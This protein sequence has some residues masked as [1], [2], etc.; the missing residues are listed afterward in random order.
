MYDL[1]HPEQAAASGAAALSSRIAEYPTDALRRIGGYSGAFN[2]SN[3][4]L[5]YQRQSA[6]S[7]SS[8]KTGVEDLNRKITGDTGEMRAP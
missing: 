2:S 7:L 4:S 5:N 3:P 1:Q 8:I 6:A